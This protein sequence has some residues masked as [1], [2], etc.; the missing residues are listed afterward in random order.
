MVSWHNPTSNDRNKDMDDYGR[1]GPLAAL[2]AITAITGAQRIHAAGYCLGGT[3][4][5]IA[6]AALARD[7]DKRLASL[8]FMAAQTEFSEPGELGLFI[9][10][11]QIDVI[12][13]MMW[14]RGYLAS[15][16]MGGAFQM[17][18]S[19]DLIWSRILTT[20]LMGEREA[21]NDLMAWNADGTRMPYAM[22]SEYLWKLFLGND[23]AEGRY[24]VDGRPVSLSA[25]RQPIFWSGPKPIT[26]RPGVRCTSCTC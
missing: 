22:H 5:A 16:Q 13:A 17:L 1:L 26:S 24:R 3:L 7:G 15:G 9:D 6:A 4:L 18:R 23:L 10:E 25:L 2:D 12:E 19:N 21:M 20:Y 11:A 14:T 8:T